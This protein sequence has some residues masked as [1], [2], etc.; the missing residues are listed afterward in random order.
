[1]E[2]LP[3]GSSSFNFPFQFN[4]DSDYVCL[5]SFKEMMTDKRLHTHTHALMHACS[6]YVCICVCP[7]ESSRVNISAV[8]ITGMTKKSVNIALVTKNTQKR[9]KLEISV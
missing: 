8:I 7:C 3:T 2:N 5:T 6:L 4:L 1:M 9:T